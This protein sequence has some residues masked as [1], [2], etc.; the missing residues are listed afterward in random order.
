[1][2]D[3]LSSRQ[4]AKERQ[5]ERTSKFTLNHLWEESW[6]E[7]HPESR[8]SGLE[9]QRLLFRYEQN[10]FLRARLVPTLIKETEMSEQKFHSTPIPQSD[11]VLNIKPR[12]FVFPEN[13][14]EEEISLISYHQTFEIPLVEASPI[15][16]DEKASKLRWSA[17]GYN[18]VD[19]M[20]LGTPELTFSHDEGN[21]FISFSERKEKISGDVSV[22]RVT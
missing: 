20:S 6:T 18:L 16:R 4:I 2:K 15:V 5:T 21:F 17:K 9:L 11:E 22:N 3:L 10:S 19:K 1:M 8:K 13:E 14:D 12:N 7:S